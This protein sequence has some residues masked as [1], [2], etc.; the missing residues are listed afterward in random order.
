M[1]SKSSIRSKITLKLSISM[2]I[3]TVLIGVFA[4]FMSERFLINQYKSVSISMSVVAVNQM[5]AVLEAEIASGRHS[6]NEFMNFK[7]HELSLEECKQEWT[8]PGDRFDDDYLKKLFKNEVKV[9]ANKVERYKRYHTDYSTILWDS[10]DG[11]HRSYIKKSGARP[12]EPAEIRFGYYS[13]P[14]Y[15]SPGP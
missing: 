8:N 1:S 15:H 10:E 4:Y 6:L 14:R 5:S 7:Y 2:I 3:I 9:A 12:L 11:D 13:I